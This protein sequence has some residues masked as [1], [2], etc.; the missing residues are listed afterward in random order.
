[1]ENVLPWHGVKVD[2][3]LESL[4]SVEGL[5]IINGIDWHVK[6]FIGTAPVRVVCQNTL[7]SNKE[8]FESVEEVIAKH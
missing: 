2:A 6:E 8:I 3:E 1:M 7:V 5:L 4:P